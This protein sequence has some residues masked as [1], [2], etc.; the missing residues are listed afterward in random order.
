M[1]VNEL[2]ARGV[3][4]IGGNI[5]QV[6][7]NIQQMQTQRQH[8]ALLQQQADQQSTQFNQGQDDLRLKRSLAQAQWVANGGVTKDQIA[9]QIP[10]VQQGFEQLHGPGSWATAT[11]ADVQN[12]AK[13]AVAH[14]SSQ[15]GVGPPQPKFEKLGPNDVA[16]TVGQ[17]GAFKPTY[18]A[19]AKVEPEKFGAPFAAVGPNGPGMYERGDRGTMRPATSPDGSP[20]RPYSA[21]NESII[22]PQVIDV[23]LPD[24]TVQ[25]QWVKPGERSGI[26]IGAPGNPKQKTSDT[27]RTAAGF[28][29]RMQK[30][31]PLIGT[32]KP[33]VKDFIGFGRIMNGGATTASMGN[34]MMSEEGQKYYQ[35]ASDWVRAKL[36]K[37][38]GAVIGP[39]EME[40]EIRT[41]FPL[42]GD[43]DSVITQ[44][45][46]ARATAT[47][48]ML[49]MAG[50]AAAKIQNNGPKVGTVEGGY[51]FK[52]GNPA[53]RNSWELVK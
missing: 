31:E 50:P 48:A 7:N 26:P 15:L 44:K 29:E 18:T 40:Q 20:L 8:N 14:L 22:K 4:P 11:D 16:G 21:P 13:A 51:R 23:Q 2:I 45:Q 37:E 35:A 17:D 6:L 33:S 1:A 27:E 10:D 52:G 30:A 19:P 36:R 42:P 5:P 49:Q 25:Q 12:S 24:Q 9:Q 32:G 47:D 28:L 38:S 53:D 39:Q 34:A 3:E 46:A 43:S 41:Y